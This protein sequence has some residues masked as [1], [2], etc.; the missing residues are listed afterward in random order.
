MEMIQSYRILGVDPGLRTTGY[1]VIEIFPKRVRLLE[2]GVVRSRATT[3]ELRIR[4]I[5]R[6]INEIVQEF[7]PKV[8]SLEEIYSF[9]KR[10]RTAIL[11]GHVRGAICLAAAQA[12]IPVIAYAATMI[13]KSLTGNGHAS[14]DQMQRAIQL[15]FGLKEAPDP[16]DVADALAI[17]L[18]H[19]FHTKGTVLG[20]NVGRQFPR[21]N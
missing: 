18:C 15:E 7:Q 13:K 2:A 20:E 8:L 19:F 3:L 17:A 5:Y 16:P 4:E 6:G 14:K 1:G 10:P 21:E 12:D 9:Y 11:M